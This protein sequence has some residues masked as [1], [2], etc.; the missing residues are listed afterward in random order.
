M[1]NPYSTTS[2]S[3]EIPPP[4]PSEQAPD[5]G[6]LSRLGGLLGIACLM[7]AMAFSGW[8][9]LLSSGGSSSFFGAV[10]FG[11]VAI[12]YLVLWL[13]SRSLTSLAAW[14]AVACTLV[15][16]LSVGVVAF[17]RVDQDAQGGLALVFAPIYQLCGVFVGL[18]LA[19]ALEWASR[20]FLKTSV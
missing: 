13:A 2:T 20:T 10:I 4:G 17:D 14:I 3:D 12:P 19:V 16:C 5:A 6:I 11:L 15:G 1:T 7:S 9:Y 8:A 18:C